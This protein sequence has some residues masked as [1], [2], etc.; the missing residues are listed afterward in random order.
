MGHNA[1]SDPSHVSPADAL[2]MARA[3]ETRAQLPDQQQVNGQICRILAPAPGE[4]I[5][6][7]GSGTGA[8]SR[9]LAT[10]SPGVHVTGVDIAPNFVDI[11]R[12][13]AAAD[14]LSAT[15]SFQTSPAEALPFAE[16]QFDGALAVRLLLHSADPDQVLRELARVT[17]PSG[18]VVAMDWDLG[19]VAVDHPDRELTRRLLDWRT[20]HYGGNNWS[21]RQIYSRMVAAGFTDVTTAPVVTVCHTEE[22]SLVQSLWRAAQ[23]ARDGG[24]ISQAEHDAWVNELKMRIRNGR[25]CAAITYFIVR[26]VRAQ[27]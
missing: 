2:E 1:W 12:T 15:V 9:L 6:E 16:A 8:I 26:G 14:G 19:T 13:L 4:K 27:N 25:F 7:V 24:A 3:L 18:R 5:L 21:G 10:L 11:A 20:D 23:V 22:A 17:R